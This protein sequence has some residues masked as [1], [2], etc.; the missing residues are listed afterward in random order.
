MS[1]VQHATK[2][3]YIAY[4]AKGLTSRQSSDLAGLWSA[5][6]GQTVP[7]SSTRCCHNVGTAQDVS[8]METAIC[9]HQCHAQIN[10][11]VAGRGTATVLTSSG[12]YSSP[13]TDWCAREQWQK[14]EGCNNNHQQVEEVPVFIPSALRQQCQ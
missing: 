10:K 12:R 2:H 6:T 3:T 11:Q 9:C 5:L 8:H 13:W 7:Y 14:E 1:Q 4:I